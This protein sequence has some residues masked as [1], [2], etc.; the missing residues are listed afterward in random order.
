HRPGNGWGLGGVVD[1]HGE[2]VAESIYDNG[3]TR[4]G[5]SYEFSETKVDYVDEEVV[6][7]G[8]FFRH[9]GH[10]L[11]DFVGRAWFICSEKYSNH[12]VVYVTGSQTID[13]NYLRFLELLGVSAFDI[14]KID[15]P[16]RF[17]K[18]VIPELSYLEGKFYTKEYKK[19]FDKIVSSY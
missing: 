13:G 5:G 14:L 4:F 9:L 18:I 8:F 7:F 3:W 10:F 11:M 19:M 12:K 17:R 15:R 1:R 2:I 16:T 6:W